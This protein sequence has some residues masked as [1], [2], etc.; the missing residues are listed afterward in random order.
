[1]PDPVLTVTGLRKFFIVRRGFPRTRT[2]T[3]RALDGISFEVR[4]G[5]AFGLVGESGCGKSTAGRTLLKL[6]E[7]TAGKVFFEGRD[8]TRVTEMIK[9]AAAEQ[10][11]VVHPEQPGFA[12]ITIGQLS[13]PAHD[14]RNSWRNV[15]TVSTGELDWSRPL[16]CLPVSSRLET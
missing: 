12:G 7:P 9:T 3:V 13:G 6:I 8:I 1:M 2:V 10:L 15:V 4:D 5:E 14:P 16:P 11:P